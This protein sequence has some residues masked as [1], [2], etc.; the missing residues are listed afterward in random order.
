MVLEVGADDDP[1]GACFSGFN[2]EFWADHLNVVIELLKLEREDGGLP[3][4]LRLLP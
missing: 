1:V 4:G 3:H 2:A